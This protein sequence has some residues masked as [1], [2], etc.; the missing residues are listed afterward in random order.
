MPNVLQSYFPLIRTKEEIL[1]EIHSKP[2][3]L[4]VFSKWKSYQQEEFL[5]FCCGNRGLKIMYDGF[6]KEVLNPEYDPVR[7]ES[8]LT[9]MLNR[10]VKIVKVLPNDS[11][12]ITDENSLLVTDIIVELDDGSLANVEVQKIGYFFPGERC[13]CYS[14]DMLLRQ[15]KRARNT[16]GNAFSYN[17]LKKVYL[18]VLYEKSPREF[19]AFPNT[20]FHRS[21]TIFNSGLKLD[22]LQ[23]YIL[24]PL[25]IFHSCM[26]NKN[27]ETHLEAWLT[28]FSS[29]DP[30]TIVQLI[31]AYPEFKPM[32]ETLYRICLDMEKIMGFFSQE[33]KV[34]DDNTAKYMVDTLSA[35]VDALKQQKE[36]LRKEKE[37]LS[38]DN[39]TLS[40]DNETL[41]K[42]N[43]ALR[44]KL[45]ELE[46]QLRNNVMKPTPGI[47]VEIH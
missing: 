28:F 26:Q 35:E 32:Y 30:S 23:E 25:D 29:D 20:Y 46:A 17:Q 10:K 5:N 15:Y 38:K 2:D 27:I 21:E 39:E 13:A 7:L 3:L 44:Q 22:M 6:C 8:F 47:S 24:I 31:T 9:V 45:A 19:K 33:L 4:T 34:M 41:S 18:I 14:A 11:T 1:A 16:Y 42:T 43:E 12:R 36:A 40:K 37:I